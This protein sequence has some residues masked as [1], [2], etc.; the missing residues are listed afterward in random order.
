[1]DEIVEWSV[2]D[3]PKHKQARI[4][5][6]ASL[7]TASLMGYYFIISYIVEFRLGMWI[8]A[9]LTISFSLIPWAIARRI[10]LDLLGNIFIGFA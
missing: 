4:I 5:L 6:R 3:R 9:L 1:L 8:Q 10:N 7:M 2:P